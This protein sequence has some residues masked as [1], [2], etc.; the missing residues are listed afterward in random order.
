MGKTNNHEETDLLHSNNTIPF[1]SGNSDSL[2]TSPELLAECRNF[3]KLKSSAKPSVE[4][5]FT[6]AHSKIT[7]ERE[8]KFEPLQF[9]NYEPVKNETKKD[10][11]DYSN[12]ETSMAHLLNELNCGMTASIA[13]PH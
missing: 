12:S 8:T 1:A 2:F 3:L 5:D 4:K 7:N 11:K 13:Q 10:I 9:D 6:N